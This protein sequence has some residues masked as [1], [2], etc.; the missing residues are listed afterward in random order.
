MNGGYFMVDCTGLDLIKGSTPQSIPNLYARVKT[1]MAS[2]KPIV[3]V[4]A[5]WDGLFCTPIH[6][7]AIQIESDTVYCTASTLQIKVKSDDTVTI[8]NMVS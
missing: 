5:N 3:A 4:N 2:N 1:A 7:F 6:V 8:V